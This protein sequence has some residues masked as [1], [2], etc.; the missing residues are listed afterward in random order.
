MLNKIFGFDELDMSHFK[1]KQ[2]DM[3]ETILVFN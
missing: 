1:F 3:Y 2:W